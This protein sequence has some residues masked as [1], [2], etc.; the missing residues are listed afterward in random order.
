MFIITPSPSPSIHATQDVTDSLSRGKAL[1]GYSAR[2]PEAYCDLCFFINEVQNSWTEK[3]L[4]HLVE[5]FLRIPTP[6]PEKC[7]PWKW[8]AVQTSLWHPSIEHLLWFFFFP[9]QL[10]CT[11]P[12][13]FFLKFVLLKNEMG[14]GGG[15][16]E[17]KW[18]HLFSCYRLWIIIR[19]H[20][21]QFFFQRGGK[22]QGTLRSVSAS[23]NTVLG[24]VIW[25][26][27]SASLPLIPQ[28]D[29]AFV[30]LHKCLKRLEV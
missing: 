9:P 19:L 4:I 16:T 23:P 18:T 26:M 7:L 28:R 8:T 12:R 22:P 21:Q 20:F 5:Q 2:C 24:R 30:S 11:L 3:R 25:F 10:C 6:Y 1:R 29:T 15:Q 14:C 27:G 17:V 13:Q